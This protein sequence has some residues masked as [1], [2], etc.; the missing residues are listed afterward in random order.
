MH[1]HV[2]FRRNRTNI[3]VVIDIQNSLSPI[4]IPMGT[5]CAPFLADIFP[6]SYEA[7]IIQS[8]L[9]IARKRLVSQFNFPYRYIDDVLSIN[10]QTLK[11]ISVRCIP[12]SLRLKTRRSATLLLPTW[13]YSC[14]SVGTVNFTLPFMTSE[15]I[16]ISILQTFLSS[17]IPSSPAYGSRSFYPTNHLIRQGLLLI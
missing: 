16:L 8:L 2:K 5:N 17:N 1:P 3:N 14:Q 7:E 4:G 9:S 10:N 12:L 6:Y 11:I 15:T 13:T